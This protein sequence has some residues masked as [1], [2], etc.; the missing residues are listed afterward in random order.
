MRIYQEYDSYG[1]IFDIVDKDGNG[2]LGRGEFKAL[3]EFIG[4]GTSDAEVDAA[5]GRISNDL[6]YHMG[7]WLMADLLAEAPQAAPVYCF[8]ITQ[9]GFTKHGR[10]TPLW[11]G[12]RGNRD[13]TD[14]P[15]NLA[16]MQYL[17]NFATSGDPNGA[18]LPQWQPHAV[19]S[20]VEM[21]VGERVGMRPRSSAAHSR[22]ALVGDYIRK[23]V[24]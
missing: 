24:L 1:E 3:L 23:R 15:P 18:G 16:M 12:V 7:S 20:P 5:L 17:A 13:A 19:N 21:E 11:N 14:L 4:L 9:P 22:Y 2:S 6:W 10:D 8:C